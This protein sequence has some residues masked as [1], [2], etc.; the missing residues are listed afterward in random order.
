[1]AQEVLLFGDFVLKSGK[2]SPYFFNAGQF[3]TGESLSILA[4]FYAD[5]IV[6]SKIDYD[7]LFGPAYKG[8][9]LVSAVCMA[10]FKKYG[11]NKPFCFNRKE[12]KDHGEGGLIVG[13]KITNNSRVLIIDDVITRGT[14]FLE[15]QKMIESHGA[16]VA[17]VVISLDRQEKNPVEAQGIP[18][19]S[20][21][22]VS[23]LV[24]DL[25]GRGE[26]EREIADLIKK[27]LKGI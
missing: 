16:V 10:L 11:V 20:L 12:V 1:M 5:K 18:I 14:A 13:E 24:Q 19:L 9:P 7:L 25:E 22:T 23:E 8:I 21:L 4:E 2:R 6:E 17:G 27:Y 26:R 15:S 3:K